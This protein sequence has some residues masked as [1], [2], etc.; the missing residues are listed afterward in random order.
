VSKDLRVVLQT[1]MERDRDR[2][3][4][5]ALA[6]AEDLRRVRSREPILA[7]PAGPMLRLR[8]WSQRNPQL[9]ISLAG[10][11]VALAAGLA[12]ALI[13]LGRVRQE[14]RHS[15]AIRL[16]KDS[17]ANVKTDPALALLLALEAADR[18]RSLGTDSALLASLRELKEQR[19]YFGMSGVSASIGAGSM[20]MVSK[21]GRVTVVDLDQGF[22][23]TEVTGLPGPAKLAVMSPAGDR[24]VIAMREGGALVWSRSGTSPLVPREEIVESALF[25]GDGGRIVLSDGKPRLWVW[26]TKSLELIGER[27]LE[28]P[29]KICSDDAGR[30][31][32]VSPLM[33]RAY[34]HLFF[35]DTR[36]TVD[37]G[38]PYSA[39]FVCAVLTV[40]NATGDRVV[41]WNSF[42]GDS[43]LIRIE[44][45][46]SIPAYKPQDGVYAAAFGPS[47]SSPWLAIG[48][49]DG[50]AQLWNPADGS[51]IGAPLSGHTGKVTAVAFSPEG[52]Y[53]ATGSADHEVRL[54]E[55][56][57]GA[58]RAILRGHTNEVKQVI[59]GRNAG[60]VVS[61]G[62]DDTV[63]VWSPWINQAVDT[64]NAAEAH[65]LLPSISPLGHQAA[66]ARIPGALKEAE[67]STELREVAQAFL[68]DTERGGW[69][70]AFK[71]RNAV[72]SPD[73]RWV[74]S[75]DEA[76][77]A[78]HDVQSPGPPRTVNP[79]RCLGIRFLGFSPDSQLLAIRYFGHGESEPE[80]CLIS[81]RPQS[82]PVWLQDSRLSR[83]P[84]FVSR[85]GTLAL[86]LP[87]SSA[88]PPT[89]LRTSDGGAMPRLSEPT[90]DVITAAF[91]PDRRRVIGGGK[92]GGVFVWDLERWAAPPVTF[93]H[94]GGG[95]VRSVAFSDDGRL[96]LSAADD[97]ARVWALDGAEEMLTIPTERKVAAAIFSTDHKRVITL[98]ADGLTR[99]WPLSV[100]EEALRRKPREL[101][102]DEVDRFETRPPEDRREY[103]A[104]WDSRTG[105]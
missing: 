60:T 50:T 5:T 27:D 68:A 34:A 7:R 6:F 39:G 90:E 89:V 10:L 102:P 16:T 80:R 3:Y 43:E 4:Q 58:C 47:T 37:L 13:L 29:A 85:D 22:S 42:N 86:T 14:L 72:F 81:V 41:T 48:M 84:I 95:L 49:Y 61:L 66:D 82:E 83:H 53:F 70:N 88:Q 25:S 26:D 67:A 64:P 59:V 21:M 99:G 74:A 40:L 100:V 93:R 24:V 2:R 87:H 69:W 31:I 105:R 20:A 96:A 51:P 65:T 8:R 12:V 97:G 17:T 101:T 63:R 62:A 30:I 71:Q 9:A 33:R 11:F 52:R 73:G 78:L 76:R 104:N 56:S 54:W 55:T 75:V 92:N 32:G 28:G 94:Q 18:A 45:R 79:P 36:T 23:E 38:S 57:S 19:T 44:T 98:E 77:V 46:E 91:S 1:A 103:R 15:E 35:P